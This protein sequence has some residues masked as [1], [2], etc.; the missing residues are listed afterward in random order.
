MSTMYQDKEREIKRKHLS[1][2]GLNPY[3]LEIV[4]DSYRKN[5]YPMPVKIPYIVDTP[6]GTALVE[7][8]IKKPGYLGGRSGNWEQLD[9]FGL[10]LF[11]RS[12]FQDVSPN[13]VDFFY[14]GLEIH[15]YTPGAD[16]K[17]KNIAREIF[18]PTL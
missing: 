15:I 17:L 13:P 9:K 1:N 11:L 5:I 16:P 18:N 2:F 6:N 8:E 14:N 12:Y 10:R 4:L 7:M 3:A